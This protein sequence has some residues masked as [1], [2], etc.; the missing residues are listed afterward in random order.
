M[1]SFCITNVAYLDRLTDLIHDYWFDLEDIVYNVDN[2]ELTIPCNCD[3]KKSNDKKNIRIFNVQSYLIN[4][5]E[6]IG[7]YNFNKFVL[8]KDEAI[9]SILTGIPLEFT[10]KFSSLRI[11]VECQ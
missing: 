7:V 3:Q 6:K 10:I 11:Q 8:N 5:T 2:Q 4:D 1:T 9:L